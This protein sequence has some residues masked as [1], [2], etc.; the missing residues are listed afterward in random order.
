MTDGNH[1]S[2]AT[3]CMRHA[4]FGEVAKWVNKEWATVSVSTI[5]AGFQKVGLVASAPVS[6][7]NSRDSGDG[8]DVSV[9]LNSKVAELH[10]S[11]SENKAFDGV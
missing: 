4:M 2:T 8:N 6:N 10:N 5:T 9:T 1:S 7:Y 3:E 11:A